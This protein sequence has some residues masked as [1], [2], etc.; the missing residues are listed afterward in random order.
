M[1][2]FF[3]NNSVEDSLIC[4][5]TKSASHCLT[6]LF[7]IYQN[8]HWT[9]RRRDD[10]I[11]VPSSNRIK[12]KIDWFIH[13]F[14]VPHWAKGRNILASGWFCIPKFISTFTDQGFQKQVVEI[15]TSSSRQLHLLRVKKS[16]YPKLFYLFFHWKFDWI[17]DAISPLK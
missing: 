13:N 15:H 9:I 1:D 12:L 14:L 16:S 4:P 3:Q 11:V 5:R 17:L 7:P 2:F 8:K 6:K 10:H